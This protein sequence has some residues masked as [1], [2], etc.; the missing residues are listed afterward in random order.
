MKHIVR[1]ALITIGLGLLMTF[2]YDLAQPSE[3]FSNGART[4]YFAATMFMVFGALSLKNV[5]SYKTK[6]T[7]KYTPKNGELKNSGISLV[8]IFLFLLAPMFDQPLRFSICDC[9]WIRWVGCLFMIDAIT[10]FSWASWIL[11]KQYY[12]NDGKASELKIIT[13]GPYAIIRHPRLL[14]L[15]S[16]GLSTA[17]VFNNIVALFLAFLLVWIAALKAQDEEVLKELEFGDQWIEYKRKTYR[18]LPMIY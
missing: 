17:L 3:I 5:L 1:A 10:F 13:S 4:T 12:R 16:W 15:M 9:Q 14:G 7:I 2:A 8:V 11:G 6:T 18:F